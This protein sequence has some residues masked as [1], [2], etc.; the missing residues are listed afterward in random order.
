MNKKFSL[1]IHIPFCIQKCHYCDFVSF[2]DQE[3]YY[4]SYFTALY[5]EIE[6]RSKNISKPID[7]IYI[8]GG[9]PSCVPVQYISDL[10]ECVRSY[11][12]LKDNCEISMEMNP[13]TV[14]Q[15]SCDAYYSFGIN[16]IS[17]GVQSAND[18]LLHLLGRIHNF[19]D[20]KKTT[21]FL[22]KAGFDNINIDIMFGLPNQTLDDW[23]TT[24][25]K[26]LALDPDHVSVYSLTLEENT[27]FY[28]KYQDTDYLSDELDRQMYH[29][30]VNYLTDSGYQQY[31]ISNFAKAGK[32]CKHNL[33]CW[34]MEDY[35]GVGLN[36]HSYIDGV[37]YQNDEE[38]DLYIAAIAQEKSA[39]TMSREL[40]QKEKM[41]DYIFLGLRTI[42]GINLTDFKETFNTDLMLIHHNE[43]R[44]LIEQKLLELKTDN[45]SL[46]EKG[47][48]YANYVMREFV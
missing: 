14:D 38:L 37:R 22:K 35:I 4:E 24:L 20:A 5:R 6:I 23:I 8:G 9:T 28:L 27:P 2:S 30:A 3:K 16:R 44:R 7:T 45:L 10:L 32:V 33:Y 25:D 43:I 29:S 46:T 40:D 34:R 17:V 41:G 26:V 11:Y 39:I 31:E 13:G 18:R 36:A 15:T 19:N 21:G 1:Y 47:L 42:K 12:V 48:D